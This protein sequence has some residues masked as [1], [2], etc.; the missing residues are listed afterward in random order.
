[1]VANNTSSRLIIGDKEANLAINESA[2][3]GRGRI[4]ESR[5]RD[6]VNH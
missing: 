2:S 5:V 6:V 3:L 4:Y 1:M